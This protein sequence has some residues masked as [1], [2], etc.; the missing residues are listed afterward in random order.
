MSS[1]QVAV[2]VTSVAALPQASDTFHLRV[3]ERPQVLVF[4]TE[5]VVAVG[6]PTPQLSVAVAVPRAASISVAVGLQPRARAVP[7]AEITGGVLSA[8][9]VAVRVTSVAALPQ[10]SNTFHLR[11]CE[12]P[13]VLVFTTESVVAVGVPTPQLSVAVAVPRAASISVAVGLRSRASAVALDSI[14][15]GVWSAV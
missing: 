1:V 3:C 12:R 8:V 9:Q 11:V 10:A 6:V 2:R 15:S 4:T 14:T 13:Q 5:S 7:L